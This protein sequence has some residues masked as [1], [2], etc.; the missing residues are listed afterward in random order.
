MIAANNENKK[1]Y[2]NIIQNE[3]PKLIQMFERYLDFN[4]WGFK[5][6]HSGIFPQYLPRIIYQSNQCKIMFRWEQD[7]SYE[8]PVLYVSYGRLHAPVDQHTMLWNGEE[9]RCWHLLGKE[10]NFLDG[11]S[12]ADVSSSEFRVPRTMREFD[13]T[14]MAR[15]LQHEPIVR[16]HAYIWDYYGQRLFDLFDLRRP[17]LWE[18]YRSFLKQYYEHRDEQ[19]KLM[20]KPPSHITPPLYNVC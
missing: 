6:T 14:S 3:F 15:G 16:M 5:L 7:R 18:E 1:I 4:R 13:Q 17:D 12:P 9:C 19:K 20:G 2:E 11:L 10:L 8:L